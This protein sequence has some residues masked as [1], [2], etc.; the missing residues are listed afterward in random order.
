MG[1]APG[2]PR[3]QGEISYQPHT[4][5]GVTISIEGGGGGG[6]GGRGHYHG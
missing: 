2:L 6:G 4:M 1:K 3:G 5:T